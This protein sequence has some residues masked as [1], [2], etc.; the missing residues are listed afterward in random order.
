MPVTKCSACL[1]LYSWGLALSGLLAAVC[2]AAKFKEADVEHADK[3]IPVANLTEYFRDSLDTVMT[4]RKLRAEDDTA[5]YVV[6]LLTGFARSE[7][8]YEQTAAG[9]GLKP[10][11]FMLAD[12]VE[13]PSE[14]ERQH[15]LQ[16]LGDVALFVA[17]FFAGSLARSLVDVDYY[18]NMGGNAYGSLSQTPG[19]SVRVRARASIFAEL[20]SKFGDFVDALADIADQGRSDHDVL[21]QYEI[22]LRTGSRRA[23]D[24]LR[25]LGIE[26]QSS[27]GIDYRH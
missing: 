25:S 13:A 3:V 19:G 7:A 2:L 8:L 20:G 21:R 1:C 18:I 17:G 23:E 16:R 6:N 27:A 26:P 24:V 10:L 14:H 15:S 5:H 12:A 9:F 11:A 22:W 4:K